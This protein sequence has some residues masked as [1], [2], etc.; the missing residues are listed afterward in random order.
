MACCQVMGNDVALGIGA[1]SGHLE[2]N[3]FKPLIAHNLQ[4]SIRLLSDASES[5]TE[6]CVRGIA[7]NTE[8]IAE[9]L[10][11]SLMLVTALAPHIGYDRSAK[12][13]QKAHAEGLSLRDAAI[14]MG[15][16][17]DDFDRW[18]QP[19]QMV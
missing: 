13:A 2:L 10:A 15:V 9:L 4:Q 19:G 7:A 11:S 18:V 14:T 5:F 6:H 1:A 16:T 12:I 17:G 8:R 3:V